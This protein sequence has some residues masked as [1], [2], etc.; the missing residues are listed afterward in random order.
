MAL[1]LLFLANALEGLT[2]LFLVHEAA[3]ASTAFGPVTRQWV[4]NLGPVP[5]C[6]AAGAVA[7]G[8]IFGHG[9]FSLNGKGVGPGGQTPLGEKLHKARA[10]KKLQATGTNER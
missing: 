3:V 5:D 8:G 9:E 7:D 10:A 6:T 4:E 2:I 1:V